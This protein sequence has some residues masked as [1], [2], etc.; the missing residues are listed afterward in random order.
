[1]TNSKAGELLKT[2][3][4]GLLWTGQV[5]SQIGDGMHKVALLWFVYMLTGSALKMTIV[6]VLQTIPPLVWGPVVGVYLDRSSKKSVMIWVDAI[7][8]LLVLLIPGL[9]ALNV[10]T[11]GRLYMLV[12]LLSVVSTVFGPA[13]ASAVPLIVDRSKLTAANAL[14]QSTTN[15]GML[16]GPAVSGV[17]IAHVGV[18]NVLFAD[19]AT[20]LVSTLCLIPIRMQH[21][22]SPGPQRVAGTFLAE[23]LAGFRFVVVHQRTVRR[24]MLTSTFFSLGMSAFVFLLPIVANDLLRVGPVQL[25]WLW[26]ALGAGTLV[27]SAALS[28]VNQGDLRYRLWIVAAAL[29]VGGL[30]TCT[31]PRLDTPLLAGALVAA[32][33][34]STALFT[35]IVWALLQELTPAHLLGRV[36]TAFSTGGM[37]SATVGILGAGWLADTFGPVISLTSTGLVLILAATVTLSWTRRITRSPA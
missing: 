14:I 7:R 5:V 8:A 31:L 18:Q 23:I 6:G 29:A 19:A 24:L 37:A 34:G 3:D 16:L 27:A 33:G 26:S 12:F 21:A 28:L 20:F 22:V 17:A 9:R 1:M 10:L 32:I 25:G 13:L 15:L 11:L 2:R 4:F 35:P 30:A 36:F